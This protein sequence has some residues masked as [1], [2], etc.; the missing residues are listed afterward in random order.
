VLDQLVNRSVRVGKPDEEAE[1]GIYLQWSGRRDYRTR[2]PAPRVLVPI[3]EFSDPTKDDPGNLVIEGDNRKAL[4]S[5]ALLRGG[6]DVVLI[7]PPYNTGKNDLRY[8]DRRFHDPEADAEGAKFVTNQDGG[9][10]TKW[11]NEMAPTLVLIKDLMVPSGV[12]FVHIN[13]IELPRLL[14]LMEEIFNEDNHLGTIVW[15]GATDNNPSQIIV[16]HEYIVCYAKDRE[17]VPSPWKGQVNDLVQLMADEFN[18]LRA[19]NSDLESLAKRWK[20]WIRA[21]REE[22]PN[23]LR[24]KTE[25]D[26]RGPYQ[27]DADMANPGKQGYFY[28]IRHPKT[29]RPVKKPLRG[30]RYPQDTMRT[31]LE[32]DMVVFGQDETTVPHK[33]RHLS[34]DA[35][36]RLRSVI[37]MDPR[38]AALDIARLFPENPNIFRNAKPVDLEEYLLSFVAGR[39]SIILDCFAGSGTT[40]HAVMRLNKRDGGKR[41]FVMIEEGHGEDDYATTL[42]AERIKRARKAEQLPGGFTFLRV[43][44]QVDRKAFAHFQRKS[45]IDVILQT[46]A[47]GRGSVIRPIEGKWVI[48]AN[49]RREAVCLAWSGA[50][51]L[52]VTPKKLREM[53]VE[54]RRK[55]LSWPL[56]VYGSVCEVEETDD[57]IFLRLP[58]EVLANL[59]PT[60][61]VQ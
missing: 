18:R 42:T 28:D 6:V 33:K 48:G 59:M 55:G 7:D 23:A 54:A 34:E 29:G 11:L 58:D 60:R 20:G 56:R 57:F 8:S 51:D 17:H 10:H 44:E 31:L 36:D 52:R 61:P 16:E 1:P 19:E 25:V 32:D 14:M 26:R 43:G 24:R 38:T 22:L 39:D 37:E 5:L 47:S 15:K 2:V 21:H 3:P 27:P 35:A 13:D 12:I 53:F 30:W 9:R 50:S 40:G 4:V 46:D 41:R 49:H 45:V